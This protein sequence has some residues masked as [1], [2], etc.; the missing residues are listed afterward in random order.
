MEPQIRDL[1]QKYNTGKASAEDITQLEV[2][3]EAGEVDLADIEDIHELHKKLDV[4]QIP[5]PS[6]NMTLGFYQML[7]SRQKSKSRIVSAGGWFAELWQSRPLVRWAYSIVLLATGLAAGWLMSG[8]GNGSTTEINQLS[9][10]VK[11]MK[12]MMML[13]LLEKESISDRLRAVSLTNELPEASRKVTEALL[14][15]LNNDENVNV[16]LAALEAL[17]PYAND[18]GV[19]E[20]LIAS[21]ALQESPLVQI[22]LAE[23]MVALQEKGS[24]DSFRELL[25][26]EETPVEVKEKIRESIQI[27]I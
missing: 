2:Y 16:R 20:G 15:T 1:V 3:L 14:Q 5:E 21:I 26:K 19:R 18:P 22:S 23:M 27:L 12:E 25:E 9:A 24:V 17:L 7:A 11:E 8:P 13:S 4:S 10:E 6:E